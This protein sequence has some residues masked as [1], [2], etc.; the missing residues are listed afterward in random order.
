MQKWPFFQVSLLGNIDQ[1]NVSYD[2]LEL[3]ERL[4]RLKKQQDENVEKLE[5]FPDGLTHSFVPKI[6]IFPT[7]FFQAIQARKMRFT[8]FQNEKTPFQAIKT[9]SSKSRKIEI[10][11]KG[12]TH[13]FGSKTAI[14]SNIFFQAIQARKMRFTIF[15]S[16]K[17]PFQAIKPRSSKSRKIEI[18]QKGVN[19]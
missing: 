7:F 6:A 11:P 17:R 9:R 3:K 2:I 12:L 5:I 14:F 4:S 16:E 13:G 8:I 10:F 1:I 19:P 15:Q 18:F